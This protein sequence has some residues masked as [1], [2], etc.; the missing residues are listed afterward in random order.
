LHFLAVAQWVKYLS[1]DSRKSGVSLNDD[2]QRVPVRLDTIGVFAN[3]IMDWA[4]SMDAVIAAPHAAASA[5]IVFVDGVRFG[6]TYS[7]IVR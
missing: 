5:D 4:C 2:E 3:T 7:N 1:I 6:K